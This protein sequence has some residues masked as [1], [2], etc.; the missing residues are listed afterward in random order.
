[1]LSEQLKAFIAEHIHSVE[2]VEILLLLRHAPERGWTAQQVSAELRTDPDS[3]QQ[4]LADLRVRGLV[5]GAEA[6]AAVYSYAPRTPE[7][8]AL[9]DQLAF[10]YANR[11]YT[12]IDLIFTKPS[13]K[14]RVFADAFRLRKPKEPDE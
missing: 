6:S 11:R 13:D 9:V 10:A 14:I 1:V 5:A 4:R 2:Q 12:V 3:A 7:V 8:A